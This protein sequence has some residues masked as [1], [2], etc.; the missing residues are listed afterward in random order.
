ML[1]VT[2]QLLKAAVNL[3]LLGWSLADVYLCH[4]AT[5]AAQSSGD[6]TGRGGMPGQ[7]PGSR[8][9]CSSHPVP[10][11]PADL[12]TTVSY[13]LSILPKCPEHPP[14]MDLLCKSFL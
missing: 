13:R 14:V 9:S 12:S 4:A 7:V 8:G 6:A 10:R 1:G 3:K 5:G 11:A 2:L